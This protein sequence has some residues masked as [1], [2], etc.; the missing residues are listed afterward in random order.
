MFVVSKP[1]L[2]DWPAISSCR[3]ENPFRVSIHVRV[4][5]IRWAIFPCFLPSFPEWSGV[6]GL[7][8]FYFLVLFLIS[9]CFLSDP[10]S[11]RCLLYGVAGL[12]NGSG[13]YFAPGANE[14]G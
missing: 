13:R 14:R 6:V 8:F 12:F 5:V 3:S 7:F 2:I 1:G 10:M 9:E 11:V 4:G